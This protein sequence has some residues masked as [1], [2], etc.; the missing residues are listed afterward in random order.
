VVPIIN[1]KCSTSRCHGPEKELTLS[2]E[3]DTGN[4]NQA[5]QIYRQLLSYPAD[6]LNDQIERKYIYPGRARTSPL[7]WQIFGW[8]TSR[9]WDRELQPELKGDPKFHSQLL[10]ENEKR[11]IVEWIDFGALFSSPLEE[12]NK[13]FSPGGDE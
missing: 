8:N 4:R 10:T 12:P 6:G 5:E 7:V 9:P 1:S 3:N 11:V 2:S 13:P